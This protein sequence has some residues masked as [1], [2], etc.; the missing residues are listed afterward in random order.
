M[1]VGWSTGV[2]PT[3][4]GNLFIDSCKCIGVNGEALQL[5]AVFSIFTTSHA[6]VRIRYCK[7]HENPYQVLQVT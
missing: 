2:F 6:S 1:Y 7:S 3:V 4:V 5:H